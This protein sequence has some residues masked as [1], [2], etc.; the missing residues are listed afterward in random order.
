MITR[1]AVTLADH[2]G[3]EGLTMRR[4]AAEL[5]VTTAALYRHIGD[6][7]RLLASMTDLVLTETPPSPPDQAGWRAR[8]RYEAQ[9]EWQLYRRHPWLLAVLARIRPPLGQGLFDALERAFAALDELELPRT[10]LMSAYLGYSALVQGLALLW[11][12]ERLDRIGGAEAAAGIPAEL[13]ELLDPRIR[14]SLHKVFD[15]AAPPPELDFDE[16]LADAVD[17]LLDGLAV[18][19]TAAGE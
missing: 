8:M 17:M 2:A 10:R 11:S 12:S 13:A 6:R 7:D 16:L 5:G 4:L 19:R 1:T 18:R 9:Q 14:P 3:L 15:P